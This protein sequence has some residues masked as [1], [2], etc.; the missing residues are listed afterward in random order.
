MLYVE[1]SFDLKNHSP[2]FYT[3][4]VP[5]GID[6]CVGDVVEVPT[7]GGKRK[8]KVAIVSVHKK[9]PLSIDKDIDLYSILRVVSSSKSTLEKLI[10][11]IK[12]KYTCFSNKEVW[13]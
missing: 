5:D 2:H 9:R 12:E 13:F 1:C 7:F 6:V 8:S 10:K 3:Y 11:K 4:T